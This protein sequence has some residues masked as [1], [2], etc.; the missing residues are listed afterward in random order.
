MARPN[1]NLTQRIN[2]LKQHLDRENPLLVEVVDYFK[3]L[4]RVGYRTGLLKPDESF[5]NSISWWPLVSILGT[6]SAGKSSFIN[7]FLGEKIQQTGSHAVDDKFTVMTFSGDSE[8]RVLPGLAL[9]ADPRFPFYQISEEI[10]KVSE[11][12]GGRI[13]SYLQLKTCRSEKLRGAIMIDSPGFDADAQRTA[14]LSL[15]DYIID[16]SDLVIVFFDARHPEPGAMQDTLAHLVSNTIDRNDANKFVFVL[17]QIDTTANEDN[18]EDVVAA[19]QKAIAQTGMT[20]GTFYCIF[21]KDVAVSI[22][23]ETVRARYLRRRERDMAE[24]ESR[25]SKVGVE[26]IYRIVGSLENLTNLI[27]QQWVP[28]VMELFRVWR[29]RVI[30]TDLALWGTVAVGIFALGLIPV[31]TRGFQEMSWIPVSIVIVAVIALVW[32]HFY[33]RKWYADRL[34]KRMERDG[35]RSE[36]IQSFRKNTHFAYTMFRGNPV[37]WGRG[38]RKKLAKI[39]EAADRFVQSLND[40]Y[41]DPSGSTKR[42]D[43]G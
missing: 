4:D 27:E 25:I 22:E 11:G 39:R 30:L 17:N 38:A 10:E 23:D 34:V 26:R 18:L 20:A 19:W 7:S 13:D 35:L 14:I 37:G 6:F 31:I 43:E 1:K 29:K 16:L 12:D 40:R 5:A 8:V 33:L 9:D 28:K 3:Q 24:I 21:N 32:A 15:T 2:S 41:T 36:V 42:T